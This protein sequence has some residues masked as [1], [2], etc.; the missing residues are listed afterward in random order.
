[1]N[2]SDVWAIFVPIN[3]FRFLNVSNEPLQKW[4]AT[5]NSSGALALTQML[6]VDGCFL[7]PIL[8]STCD[9]R[10]ILKESAS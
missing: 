4:V 8:F 2:V 3:C 9:L 7:M 1:M 10:V 6:S 5:P